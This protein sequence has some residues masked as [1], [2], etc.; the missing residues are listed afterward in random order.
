M[1]ENKL[2]LGRIAFPDDTPIDLKTALEDLVRKLDDTLEYLYKPSVVSVTSAYTATD[3]DSLVLGDATGGAFAVNL[4]AVAT[5]TGR[6]IKIKKTDASGSAVTVTANGSEEIDGSTTYALSAQY[7]YVCI[8]SDG[9]SW[10]VVAN[11]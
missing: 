6:Q 1:A 10:H 2:M 9:T 7:K 4:P 3:L 8:I 5:V 11:N